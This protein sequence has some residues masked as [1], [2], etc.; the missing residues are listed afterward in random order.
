MTVNRKKLPACLLSVAVVLGSYANPAV[1]SLLGVTLDLPYIL[2]N[3]TGTTNYAA[4]SDLF[5]LVASPIAIRESSS[6]PPAFIDPAGNEEVVAISILVDDSG[7]LIG[8]VPGDDL[9]V[10]G[11]LTLADGSLLS[12]TLLTAEIIDFGFHNPG[13]TTD[14]FDFLF[15]VTGGLLAD[16]FGG[17]SADIGVTLMSEQSSFSGSFLNDFNGA[18]KGNIG[19]GHIPTE[20]VPEPAPLLL[21][22]MSLAGIALVRFR[23][24]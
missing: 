7:A 9:S 13:G 19:R 12:G 20:S 4:G 24:A 17:V 2:F 22:S 8:G 21:I 10:I 14:L 1:A 5:S 16:L 18:A 6:L 23:K 3:N 15:D 11:E